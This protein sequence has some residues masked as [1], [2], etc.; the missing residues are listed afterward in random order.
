MTALTAVHAELYR[1]KGSAVHGA[2]PTRASLRPRIRQFLSLA[3][4]GSA[5]SGIEL[6]LSGR[7]EVGHRERP[8]L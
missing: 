3:C 2:I 6:M 4:V 5:R 8:R 1:Q 7:A